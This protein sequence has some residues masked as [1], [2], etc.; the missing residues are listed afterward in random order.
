MSDNGIDESDRDR[1]DFLLLFLMMLPLQVIYPVLSGFSERVILV[2]FFSLILV[3]GV[4][5]MR[6]SRHRFLIAAILALIS[7]ELIWVS[8]WH[9]ASS[10]LPLG[11][12]TLLLFLVILSGRYLLVFIRTELPVY[13]LFIAAAALCLLL[14]TIL[15]LGIYLL[16]GLYPASALTKPDLAQAL[17]S[18][19]SIIT[20]NGAGVVMDDPLPL[21][22]VISALGM[23]GGVLLIA[24]FIAKIGVWFYKKGERVL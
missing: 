13:D 6:G 3:L 19:I 7:L 23:I 24:L 11:E 5:L 17:T 10:L 21:V 12:F 8:L 2:L 15:G 20:T 16:T 18:G 1:Q 22:R 4:W 9:A 14:G